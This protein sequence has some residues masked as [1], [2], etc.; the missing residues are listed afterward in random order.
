[1]AGLWGGEGK[2]KCTF[3][4]GLF[5]LNNK[6]NIGIIAFS[7]FSYDYAA[8]DVRSNPSN[9]SNRLFATRVDAGSR[10]IRDLSRDKHISGNLVAGK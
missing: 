3:H 6:H 10:M 1:M 7:I 9:P 4:G 5:S 2:G 8:G